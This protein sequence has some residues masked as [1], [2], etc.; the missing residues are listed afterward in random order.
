MK[1][2]PLNDNVVVKLRPRAEKSG[3]LFIPE[4]AQERSLIGEVL[5]VGPGTWISGGSDD[6]VSDIRMIRPLDVKP[7]NVVLIGKHSGREVKIDGEEY[8]VMHE[9]DILGVVEEA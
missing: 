8:W 2:K 1:L 5:A 7:G 9:D 6:P 4:T 3:G